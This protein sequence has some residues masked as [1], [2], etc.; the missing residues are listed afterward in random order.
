[1]IVWNTETH[2]LD[3]AACLE[4]LEVRPEV[5]QNPEAFVSVLELVQLDHHDCAYYLDARMAQS[6]RQFFRQARVQRELKTG[7]ACELA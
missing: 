5:V 7:S 1:M 6:A 4:S 2:T 3:Y